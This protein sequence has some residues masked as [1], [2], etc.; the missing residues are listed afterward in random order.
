VLH[1][2][3]RTET[4]HLAHYLVRLIDTQSFGRRAEDVVRLLLVV[5]ADAAVLREPRLGVIEASS[6]VAS[7]LRHAA[8]GHGKKREHITS[9]CVAKGFENKHTN[10]FSYRFDNTTFWT[11]A[12]T[13]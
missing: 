12:E 1:G 11:R 5:E 8:S 3:R 13:V 10:E 2:W 6:D 9:Y 4:A 7:N